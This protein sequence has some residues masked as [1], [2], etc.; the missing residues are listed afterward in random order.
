MTKIIRRSSISKREYET[1]LNK[2]FKENNRLCEKS[3]TSLK[4]QKESNLQFISTRFSWIR[5][6]GYGRDGFIRSTFD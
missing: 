1:S 2:L 5:I 4:D 6:H 3:H